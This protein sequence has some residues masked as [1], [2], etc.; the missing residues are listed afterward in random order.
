MY[1]A[2]VAGKGKIKCTND[3]PPQHAF[4]IG[5]VTYVKQKSHRLS[6][7]DPSAQVIMLDLKGGKSVCDD[8]L[9]S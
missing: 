3:L 8:V 7:H 9:D 2:G 6:H 4:E 1:T 5:C